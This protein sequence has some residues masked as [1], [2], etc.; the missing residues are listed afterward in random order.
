MLNCGVHYLCLV[1][2]ASGA[3][4]RYKISRFFTYCINM[5]ETIIVQQKY[6][7]STPSEMALHMP[8]KYFWSAIKTESISGN[9]YFIG[10]K[11]II[12]NV[13]NKCNVLPIGPAKVVCPHDL[14]STLKNKCLNGNSLQCKRHINH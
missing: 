5:Q 3:D 14:L 12:F 4:T 9:S 10:T 13:L 7:S 8:N 1:R 11:L 6:F 2:Y